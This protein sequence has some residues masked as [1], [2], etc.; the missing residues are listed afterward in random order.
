M[1]TIT[2][3]NEVD[4]YFK[5]ERLNQST[6]K[7]LIGGLA[8]FKKKQEKKEEQDDDK[9]IE[10]FL[11]GGAVDCILTAEEN[12]FSELY[13]VS[14]IEKKPSDVEIDMINYVFNCAIADGIENVG[15]LE[16]YNAEI[17][18]ATIKFEWQPRWKPETKVAKIIETGTP[19]FEDLKRAY[20]KKILSKNQKFTIDAVVKSLRENPRTSKYFDRDSFRS[21]LSVDVYYQYI[22]Y[23]EYKGI[24]CKAMLDIL[25]V[26]KDVETGTAKSALI[27]DIKT[28]SGNTLNFLYNVRKFRY[29]IQMAWYKMAIENNFQLSESFEILNPIFVVESTT[30]PGTPLIYVASNELLNTGEHGREEFDLANGD[31]TSVYFKPIKGFEELLEDYKYYVE[32]EWREDKIIALNN[33][34]LDI[35]WDKIID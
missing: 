10:A 11:I 28:M 20:G 31:G 18:E 1:I 13:Y 32:S 6:L 14:N 12:V 27:I 30:A 16:K 22:V 4:N 17:S 24:E 9:V 23:F 26:F 15:N 33:G 34:V 25:M 29:D 5:M 21:S 7:D 2:P 19:Y 8:A 3:Q 35:N